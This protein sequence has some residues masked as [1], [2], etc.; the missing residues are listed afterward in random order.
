MSGIVT[1]KDGEDAVDAREGFEELAGSREMV[2]GGD[3]LDTCHG[4][5][6]AAPMQEEVAVEQYPPSHLLF[7]P[8]DMSHAVGLVAIG[9]VVVVAHDGENAVGGMEPAE[10]REERV[11]LVGLQGDDVAG[12]GDEVGLEGVGAVDTAL[13]GTGTV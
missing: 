1:E 5:R 3:I 13:Q 10:D 6:V 7:E 4:D 12:E 9:A 2:G 11:E 8:H